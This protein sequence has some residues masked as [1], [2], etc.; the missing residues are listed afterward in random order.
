M[1]ALSAGQ[2]HVGGIH[3]HNTEDKESNVTLARKMLSGM[4]GKIIGFTR[5]DEGLM[6]ARGNP[7]RIRSIPDLT[8]PNVRLVNREC[9]AALRI[10]LDQATNIERIEAICAE[11]YERS[12]ARR[13]VTSGGTANQ[14]RSQPNGCSGI[15]PKVLRCLSC[16]RLIGVLCGRPICWSD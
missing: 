5:M 11:L 4:H 13:G 16:P 12:E 3:L 9:G 2:A 1:Q 15:F 7:H 14:L 8:K 6:V 10:L